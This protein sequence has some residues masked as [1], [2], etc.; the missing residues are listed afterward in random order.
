MMLFIASALSFCSGDILSTEVG[1]S[2]M[3]EVK[4]RGIW[5]IGGASDKTGNNVVRE[6][7][8][9]DPVTD[10]WYENVAADASGGFSPSTYGMAVSVKGKIYVM[11]G[12]ISGTSIT[13][14]VYEYDI[15]KNAWSSKASITAAVM[16]SAVYAHGD[17][18][19]LMGGSSSATTITAQTTHY[20]MDV[21]N[22]SWSAMTAL[23]ALRAGMA[24]Y[25]NYGAVVHAGG[26]VT[27]SGTAQSTNDIYLVTSNVYT[28]AIT[29]QVLSGAR[30][31]MASAGYTGTNG[32]YVFMV[33]G[34]SGVTTNTAYFNLTNITYVTQASSFIIYTPPATASG[35]FTGPYHPS[36]GAAT[37][38]GV[39]GAA[40]AVSP[41]NGSLSDNPTLYVFGGLRNIT[42]VDKEVWCFTANGKT[43][44]SS[45]AVGSA[46]VQKTAMPRARYGHSAVVINE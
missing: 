5:I 20:R 6:L 12:A 33:G 26:R 2:S 19:Y 1:D 44:G 7:D 22:N 15:E 34:A 18:I 10:T 11:G 40:A 45:Y 14:A 16:D 25:N 37:T 32:T 35:V 28:T 13:N 41:Y 39:M 3:L 38:T 9:Y 4:M 46:W 29:E 27:T 30:F 36:F 8:L 31:N 17:M 21:G 23:P 24:V 42:S 43:T